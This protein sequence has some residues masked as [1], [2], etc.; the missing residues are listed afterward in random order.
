MRLRIDPHGQV[1]CV[2][3]EAIDLAVLGE[4]AIQRASHVEPDDQGRW[5]ADLGPVGGPRLGPYPLRSL[6]LQ[7][8]AAWLDDCLFPNRDRAAL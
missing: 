8:E 1:V 2:Y 6:A 3:G 4:P 7:A 5:W